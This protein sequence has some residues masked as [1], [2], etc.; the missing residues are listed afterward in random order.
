M[1]LDLNIQ[2]TLKRSPMEGA[3]HGVMDNYGGQYQL[4]SYSESAKLAEQVWGVPVGVT[5]PNSLSRAS[6]SRG[7]GQIK[8]AEHESNSKAAPADVRIG[9]YRV[10]YLPETNE[11]KLSII[12]MGDE[13]GFWAKLWRSLSGE[14]LETERVTIQK[15]G[16]YAENRF[17]TELE[18]RKDISRADKQS[19]ISF[20]LDHSKAVFDNNYKLTEDSL[21]GPPTNVAYAE[22]IQGPFGASMATTKKLEMGRAG[23]QPISNFNRSPG[24]NLGSSHSRTVNTDMGSFHT[25]QPLSR[26]QSGLVRDVLGNPVNQH[27][28]PGVHVPSSAVNQHRSGRSF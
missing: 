28:T 9:Q 12:S 25:P 3:M 7:S 27:I 8:K 13:G 2:N 21:F 14:E 11:W 4:T 6:S 10:Q 1:N 5:A 19:I 20:V 16:T 22:T 23:S 17:L 15:S 24:I 18:F 26:V